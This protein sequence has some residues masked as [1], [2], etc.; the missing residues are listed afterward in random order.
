[1]FR[2]RYLRLYISVYFSRYV[3]NLTSWKVTQDFSLPA[4]QNSFESVWDDVQN[5]WE[6]NK[7][8]R[9]DR[10]R[11]LCGRFNDNS[12]RVW[13]RFDVI[14]WHLFRNYASMRCLMSEK[15]KI[16]CSR[17]AKLFWCINLWYRNS[18]STFYLQQ[19]FFEN[20]TFYVIMWKQFVQPSRPQMIIWRMRIAFWLTKNTNTHSEYVIIIPFPL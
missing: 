3:A 4:I 5:M 7:F 1:M 15:S 17:E 8:P 18:K 6:G 10:R 20:H 11:W 2:G 9:V 12:S 14:C 16:W 19:F 13:G